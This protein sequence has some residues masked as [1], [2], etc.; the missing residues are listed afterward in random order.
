[1]QVL[2][3]NIQIKVEYLKYHADEKYTS[4]AVLEVIKSIDEAPATLMNAYDS[5]FFIPKLKFLMC[6]QH[7]CG[8]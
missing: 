5:L 4:Q 8:L 3:I 7:V 6:Q 2:R 1:M